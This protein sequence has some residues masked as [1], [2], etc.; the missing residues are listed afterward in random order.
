MKITRA[1]L[2]SS[3]QQAETWEREPGFL[4]FASSAPKMYRFL[5]SKEDDALRFQIFCVHQE[6]GQDARVID[7]V[8]PNAHVNIEFKN[9]GEL[10]N[11]LRRYQIDFEQA[12][13]PL[14]ER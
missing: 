6:R 7:I 8:S 9:M 10:I 1:L 11:F 12:W 5:V 14:E 2:L 3:T 13:S 4:L